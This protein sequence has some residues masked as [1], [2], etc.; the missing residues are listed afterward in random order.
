MCDYPKASTSKHR[1]SRKP[2]TCA[3]CGGRIFYK[4]KYHY[5]TAI[6]DDSWGTY[7]TCMDCVD[8]RASF[9]SELRYDDRP[10]IGNLFN[11][12]F[13]SDYKPDIQTAIDIMDKRGKF[14]QPWMRD[15][16]KKK[17]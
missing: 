1:I 9:E 11:D 10:Y 17:K 3:E 12:I 2:H 7:K 8:L 16:L 14:V 13:E 6:W 4:E 5:F 15:R